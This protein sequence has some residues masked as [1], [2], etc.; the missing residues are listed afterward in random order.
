[1]NDLTVSEL[2]SIL[3]E[4]KIDIKFGA[5]LTVDQIIAKQDILAELKQVGLEY[6]FIGVET[7]DPSIAISLSKNTKKINK[8]NVEVF[9]WFDRSF[10]ALL[11][12]HEL[13]IKS[14]VALVFGLGESHESRLEILNKL[15]VWRNKF[16]FPARISMNWGVQ[17]PL[18]EIREDGR[19]YTYHEW[20]AQPGPFLDAFKNFGESSLLYPLYGQ[21]RPDLLELIQVAETAKSVVEAKPNDSVDLTEYIDALRVLDEDS[22][23]PLDAAVLV[24]CRVS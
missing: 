1:M 15:K 16:G 13:G 7:I 11:K 10:R 3:K 2:I 17:H 23:K 9:S 14:C 19:D 12:L 21:P 24:D 8:N 20:G 18:K 5:Q 22:Q 6:L 4:E